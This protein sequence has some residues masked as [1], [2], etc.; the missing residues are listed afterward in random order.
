MA[1]RLRNLG[2]KRIR[3]LAEGL[4][5]WRARGFPTEALELGSE[6]PDILGPA[7]SS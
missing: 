2:I 5:G 1:L 3:P 7:P 4:A 6:S